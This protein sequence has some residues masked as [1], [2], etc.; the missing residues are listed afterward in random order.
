[1]AR[2]WQL[3]EAKN[4]LSEVVDLALEEGPQI[5]TRHGKEV[6]VVIA[7]DEFDRR[8]RGKARGTI[9]AFLRGLSFTKAGLDL[10]RSKDL[11][12]DLEF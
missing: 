6:A 2:T 7:K 5:V 4:R 12:R 1:M 8:R 11:D 10:S 9:V 3:Q